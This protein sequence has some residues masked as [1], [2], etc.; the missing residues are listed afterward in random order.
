MT[1]R[2]LAKKLIQA[3]KQ[4]QNKLAKNHNLFFNF[5]KNISKIQKNFNDKL[6]CFRKDLQKRSRKN[7]IN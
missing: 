2:L 6:E 4:K 7:D 3:G 5:R 1:S